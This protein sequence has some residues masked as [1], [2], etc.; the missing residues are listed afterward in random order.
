MSAQHVDIARSLGYIDPRVVQ[1][2]VIIKAEHVGAQVVPHQDGCTSYTDPPSCAT[3]W[4]ALEDANAGNGCLAVVPGSHRVTPITRRCRQD[5]HGMPSFEP[6]EPIFAE[7]Q[8]VSAEA[9]ELKRDEEGEHVYKDLE[10][11]AGTLV[12][13]QG[14][15]IHTSAA[16]TSDKSRVAFNFGVVEGT[17]KWEQDN[18]LQPYEGQTEFEKLHAY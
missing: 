3:F 14:N 18:Y 9:P 4:Y 7:I 12:L 8:G 10:V 13:R 2:L 1:S 15:L 16:N 5:E 11:K 6:Q 17:L